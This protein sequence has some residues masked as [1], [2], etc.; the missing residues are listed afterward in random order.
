MA[1]TRRGRE[2]SLLLDVRDRANVVEVRGFS[3]KKVREALRLQL[4]ADQL[5]AEQIG[6]T[7]ETLIRTLMSKA[8]LP[9]TPSSSVRQT[10]RV[11]AHLSALLA[12]PVCT[13]TGLATLR[14]AAESSARTWITRQKRGHRVFTV[15]YNGRTLIPLF[16]LTDAGDSR[17]DLADV[18]RPLLE[19]GL[20]GW[21]VWSWLTQPSNLLSGEVPETVA[22]TSPARASTAARRFAARPTA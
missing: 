1:G 22:R 17:D 13:Y 2:T 15:T 14:G 11:A 16:Q 9:I 21:A 7:R 3:S 12:T 10:E 18:L 6:G 4:E 5:R 20:D 19:A 8:Q